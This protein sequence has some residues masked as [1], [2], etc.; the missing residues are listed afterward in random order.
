[1]NMNIQ[2]EENKLFNDNNLFEE[3]KVTISVQRRNGKK[4][5]TTVIGMATDLDLPKIISYFKKTYS[6]NGS[7]LKDEK[8]GEVITLSGDQ[9]DNMY[10]FLINEEINKR[11]DIIVKGV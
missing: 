3:S 1:M 10:N 11:E 2:F 8:Y 4:C 5:I 9:K 6:C 7:I